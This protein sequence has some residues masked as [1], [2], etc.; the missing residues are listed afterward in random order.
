M[1]RSNRG[2]ASRCGGTSGEA[3]VPA[4]QKIRPRLVGELFPNPWSDEIAGM[5]GD[6]TRFESSSL[7][8]RR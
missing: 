2:N 6:G 5:A 3:A 4:P 1:R 7:A 8:I